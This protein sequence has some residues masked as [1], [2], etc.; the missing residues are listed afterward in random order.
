M[1][2]ELKEKA[3]KGVLDNMLST[4]QSALAV[5]AGAVFLYR[6]GGR[7]I[8]SEASG[9]SS[10][11]LGDIRKDLAEIES[12]GRKF[13]TTDITNL[14]NRTF[15]NE[16]SHFKR[17]KEAVENGG[18]IIRTTDQT[19]NFG[20]MYTVFNQTTRKNL[21]REAGRLY[22]YENGIKPLAVN[23]AN[24]LGQSDIQRRQIRQLIERSYQKNDLGDILNHR[25]QLK[26]EEVVKAEDVDRIL[27]AIKAKKEEIKKAKESFARQAERA[28]EPIQQ[29]AFGI[30]ALMEKRRKQKDESRVLGD[31]GLTFGEFIENAERFRGN[32]VTVKID[33]NEN[34]IT[35]EA[36]E[37]AAR[38]RQRVREVNRDRE[39]EAVRIFNELNVSELIRVDK[40]GNI[41]N[42]SDAM[43]LADRA[44]D[45]FAATMPGKIFKV[46]DIRE[47]TK[48][49]AFAIF[50]PSLNKADPIA[51]KLINEGDN[52]NLLT[53]DKQIIRIYDK[54]F[55]LGPQGR[56]NH[57]EEL[58][59]TRLLSK[60]G[61]G[62][63]LLMNIAGNEAY[64]PRTGRKIFDWLDIGREGQAH[65]GD[66]TRSMIT[67]LTSPTW[68]GNA[69]DSA[70]KA[71]EQNLTEISRIRNNM[72][73]NKN[74]IYAA[75]NKLSQQVQIINSMYSK[76]TFAPSAKDALKLAENMEGEAK[77]YMELAAKDGE[78]LIQAIFEKRGSN[79]GRTDDY[80][81]QDLA[82][83]LRE[84]S[85]N[86]RRARNML[87]I[88]ENQGNLLENNQSDHFND[89]LRIELTKEA[90]MRQVA[91]KGRMS[92]REL[93]ELSLT[94]KRSMRNIN[95]LTDWSV[96]QSEAGI[97][98]K[99]GTNRS[100]DS[101]LDQSEKVFEIY[102]RGKNKE[103]DFYEGMHENLEILRKERISNFS[104]DYGEVMN[105][106]NIVQAYGQNEFIHIKKMVSPMDLIQNLNDAE[107]W[108]AFAKQWTAGRNNME[109]VTTATL[110]PYFF[111]VR[112]SDAL[113]KVGLS[114]SAE[115]KGSTGSLISAM[116][117]KRGL[118]IVG[119][120][121]AYDYTS[122][123]FGVL[124][125]QNL[126]T[127]MLSG[128]ANI[129]LAM[130]SLTDA[131]GLTEFLK[132]EKELN[133]LLRYWTGDEYMSREEREDWYQNGYQEMRKGRWWNFGGIQEFRGSKVQYYQ[134]NYLRRATSNWK[135]VS[136]YNNVWDKWSHSWIPTPTNPISPL[137]YLA[138]PYWME[139]RFAEDRPY[140]MT[141]KMF[142][143]ETPW[144][145]ILNATIG[146]I[147]KPQV[148]M[149]TDRLDENFVDSK[150]L[151]EAENRAIYEKARNEDGKH[152]VRFK[153]GAIEPVTFTRYDAP[154]PSERILSINGK[155]GEYSIEGGSAYGS[156]SGSVYAGD[157]ELSNPLVNDGNSDENL[158]RLGFGGRGGS[159]GAPGFG[160][161]EGLSAED[162]LAISAADGNLFSMIAQGAIGATALGQISLSNDEIYRRAAANRQMES[163]GMPKD[164]GVISTESIYRAGASF[165]SSVLQD[166]EALSELKGL[167]AGDDFLG[168][169]AYTFRFAA[170]IYGYGAY[171]L[172]PGQPKIK[173]AD[174]SDINSPVRS[175]WDLNTGGLGGGYLEIFR[176]F[177][178]SAN[179]KQEDFNPLLNTMPDWMPEKFRF[180]DPYT[181]LPKGEMRMPG[182]GYESIYDLHPD[183]YGRY[184]AFDRMKILADIAPT[185]H[186]YKVWRDI[187]NET[188]KDPELR[189]EM[190]EI[191]ERVKKQNKNY[192]FFDYR[193]LGRGTNR[194][195]AYVD[196][197]IDNNHFTV[198]GSDKVY[199][200]AGIDVGAQ[201]KSGIS[202]ADYLTPGSEIVLVTD[203]NEYTGTNDD[204]QKSVSA[205]VFSGG[206]NINK[207]LVDEGFAE[208]RGDPSSAAMMA[209][210][211]DFQIMRGKAYEAISHLPIPY[212]SNK[213]FKI[214]DPLESW[215][216]EF[217]YGTSYASWSNPIESFFMPAVE[218]ALMSDT[219]IAIGAGLGLL[220]NHMQ[221]NPDKFSPL[222]RNLATGAFALG[223]RGAFIGGFL[224]LGTGSGATTIRRA[225]NIG[226]VAQIGAWAF[227]RRDE[228]L[229]GTIGAAGIGAFIGN[230]FEDIGKAKGG[231]YGAIIGL[232]ITGM[233]S[234]VLSD[235]VNNEYIP[236]RTKEKW[237]MQEYF[238]RLTYVKY[239][240]LYEKA[241]R[242]AKILEGV[243]IDELVTNYEKSQEENFK[244]RQKLED[245]K[246]IVQRAYNAT[247]ERGAR[248]LQEIEDK[249]RALE[250]QEF[251]VSVGSYGKSA[252]M[253]KQ[254]MD[255]TVYGLNRNA[256]WAELVRAVPQNE[257]DHFLEFFK[258]KD[259]KKQKEILQYVSPY[260]QKI[261][262][263]AWG[264]DPEKLES[265]ASY[266]KDKHLPGPFWSGWRPDVDLKDVQV[267]T[268]Q[269]EGMLLADFGFYES[270]L[271][272]PEVINAPNISPDGSQDPLSL[273]AK[274]TTTLKGM[275]LVGVNV[276]VS[277]S[278][279]SGVEVMA[280][281]INTATNA[282]AYVERK[283]QDILTY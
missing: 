38:L 112:L 230:K 97:F 231:L 272:D 86:P 93:V 9:I 263:I 116:A 144:G 68:S 193:F 191:K 203:K 95:Q 149:H 121:T 219:E 255:S 283:I 146:E 165:G 162:R 127:T 82:S 189:Q 37:F 238:D 168:E 271:R 206:E 57:I 47:S 268:I 187:A 52:K 128:V 48:Q 61:A 150:V 276:N 22:E 111:T 215:K 123:M 30:E 89:L 73:D 56:L 264:Q 77:S 156:Y 200:M 208:R 170:G 17:A 244:L 207:L 277:P 225:M 34:P 192:E 20:K 213:F 104:S 107:K 64:R 160:V 59:N 12:E 257:R 222:V 84:F 235:G 138:D 29:E 217:T 161:V 190:E 81:N 178:P 223:N 171:A 110:A 266:F 16:D 186:E 63:G 202:L 46:R 14:Y 181:V 91:E 83:L 41:Y 124:T 113:S 197:I 198:V 248:L 212:F 94:D 78:D 132:N 31:R 169:M 137:I 26:L 18:N 267:K 254:M 210:F 7:K 19:S 36:T 163:L 241:A 176:R 49:P 67:K 102:R 2:D 224:G 166:A 204:N 218:R 199:S 131:T 179:H 145:P 39:E 175:F 209:N 136:L 44:A 76:T 279:K 147:V 151:I 35:E 25:N 65:V 239:S 253:Y 258:E 21:N 139:R 265:N 106:S 42:F 92:A 45:R 87:S 275:G 228:V 142:T 152:L 240:G 211:T 143:E 55:S 260:T 159:G 148:R 98:A 101:L 247:D 134:P 85:E 27:D 270:Q 220:N 173:L 70:I 129:D 232:A 245:A 251:A 15:K 13:R 88:K 182:K 120:L 243:D 69:V 174:A 71:P 195:K 246:E 54:S 24:E 118:P 153:D 226:A 103:D 154:T 62:P 164:D 119:V 114:F 184:G 227:T 172:F 252:L 79:I 273:I 167:S 201:K 274:I 32:N 105:N 214:R 157:I 281:I 1:A 60:Y 8:L 237:E 109:D 43:N 194:E 185:S 122:D 250:T 140:P 188:V 74:D 282:P 53:L 158:S 234:S 23:F 196:K 280:N 28:Y 4:A 75:V 262:K 269:N 261:L 130:R 72:L 242:K 229:E 33:G 3:E 108:K 10:R 80:Y 99:D 141:G 135:D 216:Q 180:G 66:L 58:D 51:A 100:V 249:L 115:N 6:N 177:I 117:L 256:S 125:G 221:K 233:N 90:M 205:A 40:S 259:P 133:P 11:V 155:N 183:Q 236:E 126:T 278:T 5:G 96:L 50:N